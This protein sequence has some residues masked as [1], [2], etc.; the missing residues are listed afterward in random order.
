MTQLSI[1]QEEALS[2]IMSFL[3][4]TT[5]EHILTGGPGVGKTF[6][7]RHLIDKITERSNGRVHIYLTATTN[8]AA[9][10]LGDMTC[11]NAQT[12]HKLLNL[13]VKE[14]YRT[15]K[16]SISRGSK[17]LNLICKSLW[18]LDE[19]SMVN[20]EL[21]RIILQ[22]ADEFQSKIL[23]VGDQ[24]QLPP[25]FSSIGSVFKHVTDISELNTIH[26]QGEHSSILIEA[27]KFRE[28]IKCEEQPLFP[29]LH[30]TNDITLLNM[31]QFHNKMKEVFN[32]DEYRADIDHAKVLSWTNKTVDHYSAFV[33]GMFY[34]V[35]ERVVGEHL[36]VSNCSNNDIPLKT[37]DTIVVKSAD[38]GELYGIA[39]QWMTVDNG[40][41][42]CRIFAA[43]D[44][45]EL[46]DYLKTLATEA[47]KNRNWK[48]FFDIKKQFLELRPVYAS[49]IHKAQG[50]SMDVIFL[51]ISDV[52]KNTKWNEV[53][54]L[55]YVALTRARNHVYITGEIPSRLLE[56][57]PL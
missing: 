26:R 47:K 22:Y 42:I 48:E 5:T 4:G 38:F 16:T 19:S 20:E 57:K 41:D 32:T 21:H 7:V 17:R 23:Y 24:Y 43:S 45:S 50:G 15:G 53:A 46:Q 31:D 9:S 12:I 51:D 33:R 1:D 39:G 30:S 34:D 52:G 2:S 44:R 25:V 8:K 14:N 36:I 3:E 18:I 35:P 55:I 37:E 29:A 6:T 40:E 13:R 27:A 54:R 10:V 56:G 11:T 28:I 49:T